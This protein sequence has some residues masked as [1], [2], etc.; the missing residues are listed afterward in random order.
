MLGM[1]GIKKLRA[2]VLKRWCK[3]N[4]EDSQIWKPNANGIFTDKI[5]SN[6]QRVR[7]HLSMDSSC[8]L[9]DW[10]SEAAVLILRDCSKAK[11]GSWGE[12]AISFGLGF[13]WDCSGQLN[14]DGSHKA[15]FGNIGAG[16]VLRNSN[17]EWLGG[18]AV[19]LGKGQTSPCC[20]L[21]NC[22]DF[23]RQFDTYKI[24]HIFREKNCLADCLANWS[25][26]LDL[27]EL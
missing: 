4:L 22:C 17:G 3:N 9:N 27:V 2:T 8:S 21:C 19:N 10:P 18:F 6:D 20:L 15:A 1:V 26:N 11:E 16:G 14:V 23:L 7:R 12:S 24:H 25:F 13:S 5:I